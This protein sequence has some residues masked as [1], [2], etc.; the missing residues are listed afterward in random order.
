MDRA[1]ANGYA[2]ELYLFYFSWSNLRLSSAQN[3]GNMIDQLAQPDYNAGIL[4]IK[5][6]YGNHGT[7]QATLEPVY[8]TE[9]QI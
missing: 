9:P 2:P 4:A 8:Q 5:S 1:A 7:G 3:M 6:G